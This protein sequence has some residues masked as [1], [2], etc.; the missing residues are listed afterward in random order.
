MNLIILTEKLTVFTVMALNNMKK[1][2]K[3]F[4]ICPPLYK[5]PPWFEVIIL[6]GMYYNL[7]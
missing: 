3:K 7:N 2:S 5:Y 4:K 6:I 1:V